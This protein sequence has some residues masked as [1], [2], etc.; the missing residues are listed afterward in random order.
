MS[1]SIHILNEGFMRKYM[2]EDLF[3]SLK[4][5]I[6]RTLKKHGYNVEV[7]GADNVIEAAAEYIE[8][9]RDFEPDEDY[10]VEDWLKGTELNYPE[11]LAFMKK[12]EEDTTYKAGPFEFSSNLGSRALDTVDKTVDKVTDNIEPIAKAAKFVVPLL[13][14]DASEKEEIKEKEV[15]HNDNGQEYDIIERSKTGKNALLNKGN[16]WIVAWNC[17]ESNE[18]SWGQGHYFFDEKDARKVWQDKYLDE[19]FND[20]EDVSNE[21]NVGDSISA[22]GHTFKV[23]EILYQ[24]YD[25]YDNSWDVEFLDINGKYHHWKSDLDGG[26]IIKNESLKEELNDVDYDDFKSAI[27]NALSNVI[28]KYSNKYR[29]NVSKDQIESALEWFELHFMDDDNLDGTFEE[30]LNTLT[31]AGMSDEDRRDSELLR[32][33]YRK[34]NGKNT[35]PSAFTPEEKEVMKKYNIDAWGYRGDT[36]VVTDKGR[37]DIIKGSELRQ[38]FDSPNDKFNK[39]NYA[40]RA[41]KIDDRDYAQNI[42]RRKNWNQSFDD[43]EKEQQKRDISRKTDKMKSALKSR[44]YYQSEI[45]DADAKLQRRLTDIDKEYID[46][47]DKATSD[48]DFYSGWSSENISKAQDRIDKILD[49]HKVKESLHKL[50]EAEMS[51]EDKA[52]SELL[53]SIYRKIQ[54]RSNAKLT[55]EEEEVVKK[56]DLRR[57]DKNLVDK[58]NNTYLFNHSE[59][60]PDYSNNGIIRGKKINYADKARKLSDRQYAKKINTISKWSGGKRFQDRERT[61]LGQEMGQ[62]VNDMKSALYDRRHYKSRLDRANIDYNAAVL[63]ATNQRDNKRKAAKEFSKERKATN[64]ETVDKLNQD[65]KDLLKKESLKEDSEKR[66]VK[67]LSGEKNKEILDSVIGQISD[68]IW[69]NSPGMSGY[70]LP[71]TIS[72]NGD[73][74]IDNESEI[75]DGERWIK[76]RYYDMSDDEVRRFF[77]N[78]IK[79]ISQEYLNDNNLNPYKGWNAESDE[80]CNYLDRNSGVTIGD[81]F[82]AYQA[83]K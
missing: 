61:N 17:P 51:P 75:R 13:A 7:E 37:K 66:I 58:D 39:I 27:Y 79:Q 45:D 10:S 47:I 22:L 46:S 73:I 78:K 81:A 31:E 67:G 72:N 40:D 65:I 36:K 71:V 11:D 42:N 64:K 6:K 24:D 43:A 23:G 25:S 32:S 14:D 53:R 62:D 82:L 44:R 48:K 28:F 68:G 8:M 1:K 59:E 16:K 41:R 20:L 3:D 4:R 5:E 54:N 77:A 52:D 2:K 12:L 56:Y 30:C 19:S 55:P 21:L 33:I 18:G 57:I 29:D 35:A 60:E 80:I 83:L 9:T 26:R 49:K 76:N 34:I 50:C 74:L 63:K 38:S 69:E 70:W 15:F